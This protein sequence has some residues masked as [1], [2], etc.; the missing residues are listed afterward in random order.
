MTCFC[1]PGLWW[2]LYRSL[3]MFDMYY[4]KNDFVINN[5]KPKIMF[6][7]GKGS[8]IRGFK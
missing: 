1:Y 7:E 8:S 5:I 4:W 6:L 2:G 3:G